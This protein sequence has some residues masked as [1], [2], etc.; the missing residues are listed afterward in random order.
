[1]DELS[2]LYNIFLEK[3]ATTYIDEIKDKFE[4]NCN[5]L[6]EETFRSIKDSDNVKV[7]QNFAE[8][9]KIKDK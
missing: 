2:N 6:K 4:K 5:F 8:L 3:G 9:V 1:M 7:V